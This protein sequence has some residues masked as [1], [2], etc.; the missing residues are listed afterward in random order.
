M[1]Y[2]YEKYMVIFRPDKYLVVGAIG[3]KDIKHDP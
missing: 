3:E 2:S 1:R